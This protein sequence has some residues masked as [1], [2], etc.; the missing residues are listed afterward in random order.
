[1]TY[2]KLYRAVFFRIALALGLSLL[3]SMYLY[4]GG[5]HKDVFTHKKRIMLIS[6]PFEKTMDGYLR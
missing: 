4:V 1:M 6:E 3:A 2:L 5:I